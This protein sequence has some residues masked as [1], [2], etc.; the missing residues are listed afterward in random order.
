LCGVTRIRRTGQLA[1]ARQAKAAIAD[2]QA[3]K[4][5]EGRQWISSDYL[6]VEPSTGSPQNMIVTVRATWSD[7]L[8][9]YDGSDAFALYDQGNNVEPVSARRGP[10]TVDVAYELEPWERTCTSEMPGAVCFTW[11]IVS[12][13]ELTPR[14]EWAMP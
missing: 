4:Q 14:P 6:S 12:F 10:Y 11:R 8:V 5:Y 2:L 1:C 13:E 7:Y 9:T 3:Q